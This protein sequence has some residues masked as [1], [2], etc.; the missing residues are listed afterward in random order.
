MSSGNFLVSLTQVGTSPQ[1]TSIAWRSGKFEPGMRGGPDSAIS[2][3]CVGA[4]L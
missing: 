3:G 2:T 1:R 4:M